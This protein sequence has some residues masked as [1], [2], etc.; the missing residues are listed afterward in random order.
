MPV[1]NL[2]AA[3]LILLWAGPVLAACDLP[4]ETADV[5]SVR[6]DGT[7]Q[8]TDRREIKLAGVELADSGRA[9]LPGLLKDE[10]LTLRPTGK[11]DRWNRQPAHIEDVEQN[12]I[13]KGL[14]HA[15]AQA[16]GACLSELLVTEEKARKARIG[17]W[18]EPG[19]V[20]G[21]ANGAA[22]TEHLGRH[23]LAE[24]M[25]QSARL[26]KGRVYLNFARYWKSG[27]SLII[28][29][30]DW[31][32]F[33]GGA[34]VEAIAGKRLRARGRLEYRNGPAILAGADDR[35]EILP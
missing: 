34:A 14:G 22:L 26:S 32:H 31:P 2:G 9:A 5:L 33:S 25:V 28:A 6:P 1:Q 8:L 11:P 16:K 21:A 17:I 35:I 13:E 29:E 10:R 30:K 7:I 3:A 15:A 23:V 27:L 20:L 24:G 19:Y 4:A 12:L 18:A